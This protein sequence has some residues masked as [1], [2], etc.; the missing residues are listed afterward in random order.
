MTSASRATSCFALRTPPPTS[1]STKS[2]SSSDNPFARLVTSEGSA[3]CKRALDSVNFDAHD[4]PM[5]DPVETSA[6]LVEQKSAVF[7]K[8]LRLTDLVFA[9]IILIV[10]PFWI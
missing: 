2:I 4:A 3:G 1:K 6:E 9:Q 7:T 5:A 10:G 8:E